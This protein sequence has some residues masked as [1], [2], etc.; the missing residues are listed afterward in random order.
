[1]RV[2]APLVAF[3]LCFAGYSPA[4]T[5]AAAVQTHT[6]SG[7]VVDPANQGIPGAVVEVRQADT[8]QRRTTTDGQGDFR[9]DAVPPG[10]YRVRATLAGFVTT[11]VIVP[12]G[13]EA[14]KPLLVT[15]KVG[16]ASETILVVGQSQV[17][18]G[19]AAGGMVNV[20]PNV[21][22]PPGTPLA[23]N[24][25]VVAGA[26]G[27]DQLHSRS[28][29]HVP[30][31]D[32]ASYAEISEN[33]FRRVTEHPL[34]TFSADVDTA[35]YANVRRFLNEGRLPPADAV[36]IEE[37]VNYFK[38]EYAAPRNGAPVAITTELAP[39]PW[40]P[41]HRLALVG[42]R[43]TP[44]AADRIPPRN[45]TFLLDVSGSMMPENRLPLVKTA[46]RMLVDTL[47]AD[48]RV[49]IVVYASGTGVVLQPTAGDRKAV[50]NSAIADLRA[51]GSTN[52]AGGIELAYNLASEH[53]AADGINR[54]ILATDG[55]FNVGITS[56]VALTRLIE[57]KRERGIFLSVLGVGDNNLKDSTMEMLAD[58]G[59]GNYSY[60]DS[61]QEARRVLIAEAGS[62]LVTVAKDVKLQVEFNPA[63]V[64]AYRLIGYENRL[65]KKEDFNNDRKDAGEM[66]A[67]HV[68][69]AL[70]EIVPAGEPAPSG[71]VDPLKYQQPVE[72]PARTIATNSN[73]LTNIKVRYKAPDGDASRLLE[74]PVREAGQTMT[75]NLGFAAA[76]AQ[77]GMLLRRSEFHGE[78]T[79]QNTLAL[80]REHR[81]SD[82][83][84]YRAEFIRLVDLASAL[85]VRKTD[86]TELRR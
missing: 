84:G 27:S 67:G 24:R 47:R 49:A 22:P 86:I 10:E 32:T 81:G 11:E 75:S 33:R 78:A 39:A 7:K 16:A 44:I 79:W 12:V 43:S 21:P 53:F 65:L 60:L 23:G 69:T 76:V 30:A 46:M 59:N 56:P 61:L 6:I 58:K 3:C 83:D 85:D 13:A 71:A 40:N 25:A 38:Y 36:R 54:V 52:G 17:L 29:M 77:F 34:S 70:Y 1:M 51:G 20:A 55:D 5:G 2:L 26:A 9:F 28:L 68:V 18:A 63:F 35:S 74:F 4:P 41:K 72:P 14:P 31:R 42:L 73:E 50:I 37:L 82:P 64:S 66:G 57:E 62:T 19:G 45:L 80:A 48:D 15:M 8:V